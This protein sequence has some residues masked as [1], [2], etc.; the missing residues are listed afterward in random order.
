MRY[1]ENSPPSPSLADGLWKSTDECKAESCFGCTR[2]ACL[3][4]RLATRKNTDPNVVTN[5]KYGPDFSKF[6]IWHKGSSVNPD[7]RYE[8]VSYLTWLHGGFAD[9][10]IVFSFSL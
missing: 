2:N 1:A 7:G 10:D 3:G 5:G 6:T 9:D 4:L 8:R